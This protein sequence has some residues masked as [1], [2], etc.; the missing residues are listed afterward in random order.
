MEVQ[1]ARLV[2]NITNASV[3]YAERTIYSLQ[4]S[5]T[6]ATKR[7]VCNNYHNAQV[8]TVELN[9]KI[10]FT[11]VKTIRFLL[12]DSSMTC[13]HFPSHERFIA[14]CHFT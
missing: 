3:S 10:Q 5:R 4:Q 1:R 8:V 6:I 9:L 7:V 2:A 11:T 13:Q 12:L 14:R